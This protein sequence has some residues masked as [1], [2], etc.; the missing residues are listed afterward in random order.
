MGAA[1]VRRSVFPCPYRHA[2]I[3][4][5][6][7][8]PC[9]AMPILVGTS[10]AASRFWLTHAIPRTDP[11]SY[12]KQGEPWYAWEWMYDV[13]IAAIHHVSGLNGVV[14]FTAVVISSTFALLFRFILRRS[15][16]LVVAGSLT[17]LA[18]AAAQVHMLARPHVLSWL[19]TLLWV[20]NLCRFEDGERC[21]VAV[22][23][24]AD[25]AVGKSSRGIRS[26]AGAAWGFCH[27]VHLECSHR[28]ARGG[29]PKD[30]P[31]DHRPF[32]LPADHAAHTL[33]LPVACSCVSILVQ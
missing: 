8:R 3:Q 13:V 9:S 10:G 16:N 30:S 4:P 33:R 25:V 22:A 23:S 17:L 29:S 6:E 7:C 15:G 1:I 24:A 21:G 14:L 18:I 5:D 19:L 11:F 27:R 28:S 32:G 12:T 2:C 31:T 26:G 20:E